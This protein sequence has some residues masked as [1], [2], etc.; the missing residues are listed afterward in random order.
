[1]MERYDKYKDSGVEWIGEIPEHWEVKKL[2]YGVTVNPSKDDIDKTSSEMVVFLPMEK[3]TEDGEI[4][5]SIKK[6]ISNLY[7]A[8][9]PQNPLTE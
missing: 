6:P 4:D 9:L 1:M 7:N 8:I 5:C 3:V 2:K